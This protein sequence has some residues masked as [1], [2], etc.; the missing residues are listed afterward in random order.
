MGCL[1]AILSQNRGWLRWLLQMKKKMNIKVCPAE[2]RLI[3]LTV[4]SPSD[5]DMLYNQGEEGE[6]EHHICPAKIRLIRLTVTSLSDLDMPYIY[7]EEEGD[8][9]ICPAR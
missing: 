7:G 4:T 3:R 1:K 9:Y 6:E 2:M 8:R 5:L